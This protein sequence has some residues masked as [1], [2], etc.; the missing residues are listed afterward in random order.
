MNIFDFSI[1]T[2]RARSKCG[3]NFLLSVLL[4]LR[5]QT[6]FSSCTSPE[7]YQGMRAVFF[8]RQ[9]RGSA[10]AC[11]HLLEEDLSS[12]GLTSAQVTQLLGEGT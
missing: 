10:S 3:D 5:K 12:E 2:I 4:W 1:Q 6:I 8:L 11:H 9:W 7:A